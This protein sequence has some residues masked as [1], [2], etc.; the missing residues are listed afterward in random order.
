MVFV[1][2]GSGEETVAGNEWLVA[3]EDLAERD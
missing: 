3:G 2:S 1:H